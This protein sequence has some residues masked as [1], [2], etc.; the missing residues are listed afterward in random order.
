[1][2]Q[3]FQ[4]CA[5]QIRYQHLRLEVDHPTDE[6]ESNCE[7]RR[8]K[9]LVPGIPEFV[10]TADSEASQA[11]SPRFEDVA[12]AEVPTNAP[13]RVGTAP[14]EE[15]E[16]EEEEEEDLDVHFKQKRKGEPCRKRVVK[17]PHRHTHVI[18]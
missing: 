16:V 12:G 17:K 10:A 6:A 15:V 1:M 9:R 13:D 18:A 5:N 2:V 7:G 3:D 11:E 8:Q 4:P 14:M